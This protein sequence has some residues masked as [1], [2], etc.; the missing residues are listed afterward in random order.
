LF[1]YWILFNLFAVAMLALDML[2]FHRPGRVVRS[3]DA[4]A[5]C[6]VWIA[7]AA[8]FAG[9]VFFWQGRQVALE[10]VTGYILELSL[11]VDNLFL[12]LVIFRYL[13]VPDRYQRGVLFWGILGA[14]LMRGFFIIAGVGLIH[15]FH[16]IFYGL[17]ALL[18]YSG[19]KLG[20]VGEHR[21]DPSANPAAKALRRFMRVT[22]DYHEG[23]FFVRGWQGK[24]GLYA[25]PLLIVLAV[26]ETTDLLFAVDSIPAVLAVT[27]NA[28][29]A[30]TSNVFA[31]LGL[32]SMYFAVAGL[33]K[34]FRFLHIGLAVV[35][36]LIGLKMIVAGCWQVST[37]ATLAAVA[38]V[39]L[40]S[41]AASVTFPGTRE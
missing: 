6:T 4:L 2:V 13:S 7:L 31:I 35:L 26:I 1:H 9:I 12:F 17:G 19:I 24:P 28:F 18:I 38:L 25:T 10:F 32:R 15:R 23:H 40:I 8:V 16:W 22:D 39:L 29:I 34:R 11:S 30:Y 41:V 5:W 27:L 14:L 3:R 21:I 37:L 20:L 36:I 33:M